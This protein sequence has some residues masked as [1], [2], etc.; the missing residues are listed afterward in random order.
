[1]WPFKKKPKVIIAA[2]K[3][4]SQLTEEDVVVTK[5]TTFE[6][7]DNDA[8]EIFSLIDK[9]L[10]EENLKVLRNMQQRKQLVNKMA[11]W[12]IREAHVKGKI[13]PIIGRR[14]GKKKMRH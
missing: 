9:R 12:I 3:R 8:R 13:S 11:D 4:T 5:E 2:K 14:H 6:E 7:L 1:M 10:R